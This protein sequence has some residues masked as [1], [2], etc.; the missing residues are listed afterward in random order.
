MYTD[1]EIVNK[2]AKNQSHQEWLSMSEFIKQQIISIASD[3]IE[4]LHGQSREGLVPWETGSDELDEATVYQSILLS[5]T[6]NEFKLSEKVKTMTSDEYKEG[7][8]SLTVPNK[9]YIYPL[10]IVIVNTFL[11]SKGLSNN[12][13]STGRG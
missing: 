7:N 12:S 11:A 6:I 1:I 3:Q 10:S 8:L 4:I 5:R 13:W 9:T 2:F